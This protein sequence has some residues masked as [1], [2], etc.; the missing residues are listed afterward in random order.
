MNGPYPKRRAAL[1][2]MVRE[3]YEELGSFSYG[4]WNVLAAFAI[5]IALWFFRSPGFIEGWGDL[6]VTENLYGEFQ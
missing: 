3:R 4:E 6:L 2:R 5:L 1:K